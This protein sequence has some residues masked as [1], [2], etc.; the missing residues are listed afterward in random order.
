MDGNYYNPNMGGNS[1]NPNIGGNYYNPNMAGNFG[2]TLTNDEELRIVMVG[3]TGIGKSATGNTILGRDCFESKFSSKSMT[4]DCHKG[5]GTVE[6]QKIAVIDT[7]GL[8]DTRFGMDKTAKDISQCVTYASPGPHVFLVVIRLGR[9]TEE[10]KQTVQ[11]IQEIFG[12]AADRYSM[13]LFTGGDMLDMEGTTIENFL[14]ESQDLQELVA[15][16]N[17]QYH[18]FNNKQKDRSQVTVLF[19]K[20]RNIAKKNGGSHYTNE[21]FQEAERAVEAE[22]QRILKEKEEEI[23]KEKEKLEREVKQKYE[24]EMKRINEQL[25]ADRERERKEREEERKREKEELNEERKREREERQAERMREREEKEK[26]L[27]KIKGQ[28]ESDLREQKKKLEDRYDTEAR[29]E[30][31]ESDPLRHLMKAGEAVV[32]AGKH[33]VNG[34]AAMG[35]KIGGWF[36]KVCVSS[37]FSSRDYLILLNLKKKGGHYNPNMAVNPGNT[38]TNDE[39]LR[40]VMVGKTGNGKSATG[41]IIL[42]RQCF[43]SK[44]GAQS[45]TMDCSKGKGTVDGQKVAVIDTP[46]L[47]D[48]RMG[49]ENTTKNISQCISYASPGPHVFLV[50]IRLGRY[51]EE[52]KQTV[53]MIKEIFG[54]AADRYSMILF[55]GGDM[56]EMEETT[57]EDFLAESPDLQELVARCNGQYHVFNNMKKDPSQVTVLL[58]KIRNIA[59]ENGGSHYTNEMFQEAERALD[60]EK[61]RILKE[62]EEQIRKKRE[63]IEREVQRKYEKE[64]NRIKEELEA[65]RERERKE[66][67]KE[68]KREKEEMN[69][70]R[71]RERQ[72]RQAES[73]KEREEKENELSNL[74]AKCDNDLME[75]FE[76]LQRQHQARSREE[77]EDFNPLFFLLKAVE[78]VSGVKVLGTAIRG[79]FR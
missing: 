59:Q 63:E 14:A 22:K 46:G 36:K 75:E 39:E 44:L 4:V 61:Q 70:E 32:E 72:Q 60:V 5:R 77:A 50:V 29:V 55:T 49:L 68:I 12:Q 18:V 34:V 57:I 11:R 37:V 67:E 54:Q 56:L 23:R 64:M 76:T 15:R 47:F 66:T 73:I 21:M 19:Q 41:N 51:T 53:Q 13:I 27:N 48:T 78:L 62:K 7:P 28:F 6:G 1:Y 74:R 20:I 58:Q 33:V 30:A 8:F 35:R 25:Q 38:F 9:Y 17:G 45:M 79:L 65:Q 24:K 31:E 52:E 3:K 69:E 42:G 2:Q 26:E 71:K 10:E 43:K 16:C 40:I